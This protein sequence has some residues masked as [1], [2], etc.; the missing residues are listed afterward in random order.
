MTGARS[1][2]GVW[3]SRGH[4]TRRAGSASLEGRRAPR[5]GTG[6]RRCTRVGWARRVPR[7]AQGRS[8]RAENRI[9][10]STRRRNARTGPAGFRTWLS[11]VSSEHARATEPDTHRHTTGA[12]APS[13]YDNNMYYVYT[14][15]RH[16]HHH[17][18]D[19]HHHGY[20]I[21]LL[22]CTGTTRLRPRPL[23]RHRH[24]CRCCC[25]C[26]CCC[27]V[28]AAA[29]TLYTRYCKDDNN[30]IVVV[31]AFFYRRAPCFCEQ[32]SYRSRG[33]RIFTTI[34]LLF[35]PSSGK[36]A[37]HA[38]RARLFSIRGKRVQFKGDDRN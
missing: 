23:H 8:A 10:A 30:I 2:V 21:I 19:Y 32:R 31:V 11:N 24:R 29:T 14:V 6:R 15:P 35:I 22:L 1:V 26:C 13:A 25:C 20:G 34:L 7:G 33:L 16:P 36:V 12:L 17:R 9:R 27:T 3:R 5:G 28:V 4:C 37:V 18:S 38:S